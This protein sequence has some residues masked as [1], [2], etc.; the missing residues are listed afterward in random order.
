M[1]IG[2]DEYPCY[3]GLKYESLEKYVN[4]NIQCDNGYAY[5]SGKHKMCTWIN[6]ESLG[7]MKNC[8][9]DAKQIINE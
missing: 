2:F 5:S 3:S 1:Y 7:T 9:P 6:E 8:F 4:E